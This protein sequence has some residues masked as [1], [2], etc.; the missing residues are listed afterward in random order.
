MFVGCQ[1]QFTPGTY[2]DDMGRQVDISEIPERIVSFGPNITEILFALGLDEEVVGVSD[3]CDYPEAAK[4]KP[5]VGNAFTP[6]V[7]TVVGLEPDLVLTIEH[8][9]LNAELDTLGLKFIVLDPEDIDGVL[10]NIELVGEVT[11][12][13]REA[14]EL[15]QE[16]LDRITSVRTEAE[17]AA[18]VSVFFIVDATDPSN[19]WTAGA[20]SFI[21]DIIDIVGGE[22]V[23]GEITGDWV[24]MSIEQIVASDPDIIIVQTMMGGVPTVSKET[25][26]AHPVWGEMTA[27]KQGN[28]AFI[29]GD[30]VSRPG[31]RIVD[32][33][34][35][36]AKIVHPELFE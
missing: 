20:D 18:E 21:G 19:P 3:F 33:V 17:D 1:P 2:T 7:E 5:K 12:K 8:E 27:V 24:Q 31:P 26:E 25:L 23:A 10:E 32:G 9:Q 6:S 4:D 36:M 13:A 35:E 16:M 22:N 30:L 15:G 28:I 29:N 14:E 11:G 34:E